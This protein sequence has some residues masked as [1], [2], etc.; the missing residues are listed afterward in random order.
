[1]PPIPPLLPELGFRVRDLCD[2]VAVQ[3]L[4]AIR[5]HVG[6]EDCV[7]D[8]DAAGDEDSEDEEGWPCDWRTGLGQ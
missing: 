1:M 8:W 4:F 6:W 5:G 2:W 7:A 3:E